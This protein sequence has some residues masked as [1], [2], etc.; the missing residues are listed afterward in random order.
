MP[1]VVVEAEQRELQGLKP[2]FVPGVGVAPEAA[3]YKDPSTKHDVTAASTTERCE[4]F[5]ESTQGKQEF[6]Q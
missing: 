3:T 2:H 1:E 4:P 6:A 5:V